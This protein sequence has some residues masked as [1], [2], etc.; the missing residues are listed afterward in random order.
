MRPPAPFPS[1][2]QF[3]AIKAEGNLIYYYDTNLDGNMGNNTAHV[4]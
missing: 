4:C 3:Y 1:A 2:F